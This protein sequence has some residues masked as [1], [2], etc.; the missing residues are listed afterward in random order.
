M[1]TPIKI[2][3]YLIIKKDRIFIFFFTSIYLYCNIISAFIFPSQKAAFIFFKLI[4]LLLVAIFFYK[5]KIIIN[6]YHKDYL[7][8]YALFIFLCILSSIFAEDH[9]IALRPVIINL[10]I[11]LPLIFFFIFIN[12]KEKFDFVIRI[13]TLFWIILT[14]YLIYLEISFIEYRNDITRVGHFQ[15]GGI[16]NFAFLGLALLLLEKN[17]YK[18]FIFINCI[19]LVYLSF[20]LKLFLVFNLFII[21]ILLFHKIRFANFWKFIFIILLTCFILQYEFI[22]ELIYNFDQYYYKIFV[23]RFLVLF[24]KKDIFFTSYNAS[25]INYAESDF[26]KN[27]E[28]RLDSLKIFLKNIIIGNGLESERVLIE[29]KTQAHSAIISILVGTGIIGFFLFFYPITKLF[30][31]SYKHNYSEIL[32]ISILYIFYSAIN[33]IYVNVSVVLV[34]FILFSLYNIKRYTTKGSIKI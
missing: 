26:N 16:T 23:E 29:Q 10:L 3:K 9:Y 6:K 25:E 12:T 8:A 32:I 34:F 21:L 2:K 14:I 18:F 24:D 17:I 4:P 11:T 5:K 1:N 27:L 13:V 19:L 20:S 22:L 7:I 33:P 30:F 15:K 28:I 31:L